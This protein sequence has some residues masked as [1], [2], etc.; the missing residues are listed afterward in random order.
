MGVDPFAPEDRAFDN[1]ARLLRRDLADVEGPFD[2]VH[3]PPQPRARPR[4]GAS[5]EQAAQLLT[6]GGRILV[7][8]PTVSCDAFDEYGV[9]WVQLDAPRHIT[10]FSRA[11][12]EA[13]ADPPRLARH[14]GA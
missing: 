2:L 14:R 3:V 4:P 13:L 9:D 1:G 10:L 8:M 11:G 12:V 6:P 5:L 7:R